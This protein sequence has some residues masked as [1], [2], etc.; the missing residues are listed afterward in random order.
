M[1]RFFVK[2][3]RKTFEQNLFVHKKS[4]LDF[5]PMNKLKRFS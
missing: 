1:R 5:Y 3:I 4:K 2:G